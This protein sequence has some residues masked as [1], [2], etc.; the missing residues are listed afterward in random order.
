MH[1]DGS[2][3]SSTTAVPERIGRYRII[4]EIGRGGMA[5]VYRAVLDGPG[6]FSKEVCIKRILPSGADDP[7]MVEMFEREARLAATLQHTNV[8]QVFDFDLCDGSPFLAMEYVD[9]GSLADVWRAGTAEGRTVPIE[10]AAAVTVDVLHGLHHV[11]SRTLDGRQMG[12]VHRD[13]S[14][15]NILVSRSGDVKVA[16]FG[17]ARAN[18]LGE[19]TRTGILR[20]KFAYIAP[21]YVASGSAD[22]RGDIFS[23]GVVLHELL[24]GTRR[25]PPATDAEALGW[26]L[27]PVFRPVGESRPDVP[28]RLA[29]IVASMVARHPDERPDTA[30]E[31]AAQ[32]VDAAPPAGRESLASYFGRLLPARGGAERE[33]TLRVDGAELAET[34]PSVS[35]TERTATRVTAGVLAGQPR[36]RIPARDLTPDAS[37]AV[38]RPA[39]TRAGRTGRIAK[40]A[41]PW[42][43]AAVVAIALIAGARAWFAAPGGSEV[44]PSTEASATAATADRPV[45]DAPSPAEPV[46]SILDPGAPVVVGQAIGHGVVEPIPPP[47][48]TIHVAQDA[49]L[50]SSAG[51]AAPAPPPPDMPP[52]SRRGLQ[53]TTEVHGTSVRETGVLEISTRPWAY[54]SID[55]V[56]VGEGGIKQGYKVRAGRRRLTFSN[57]NHCTFE[58][59]VRVRPGR[60]VSVHYNLSEAC[61]A[62]RRRIGTPSD[63]PDGAE[64]RS[65]AIPRR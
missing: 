34:L 47:A 62:Q 5:V 19:K 41:A 23:T 64:P 9:G 57:P 43:A 4:E 60:T 56:E 21:E 15:H 48:P 36:P 38:A 1:G 3:G 40:R 18:M 54:V 58:E 30:A 22:H 50:P 27:R 2:G 10:I 53:P 63:M 39:G 28:D 17:I 14:L 35:P 52:E 11:H 32:I 16:D 33:R 65:P 26:I 25:V 51:G 20:G 31:A 12:L 13:V 42:A 49:D 61:A 46:E 29:A 7:L 6:G 45:R 44:N 59:T 55:G 24:A 8:V 37:T